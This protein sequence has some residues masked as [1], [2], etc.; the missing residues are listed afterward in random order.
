MTQV[1]K[2]VSLFITIDSSNI[3]LKKEELNID[4]KGIIED[5]HYNKDIKRSIL[6]TSLD[7]YELAKKHNIDMPYSTLGENLLIDYNPYTLPIGTK[8]QIGNTI[9]QISQNCTLCN[10]LSKIDKQLPKLLKDDRGIFAK[11]I[12]DGTIRVGDEIYLLS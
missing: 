10:H 12:Q 11:V 6:I 5:K 4:T 9:L 2:I 1:G 3:P 8:L 7:S